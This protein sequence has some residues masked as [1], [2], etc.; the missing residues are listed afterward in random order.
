MLQISL[1]VKV[2]PMFTT[3]LYHC[4]SSRTTSRSLV[5][6]S[7]VALKTSKYV[8]LYE[9]NRKWRKLTSNFIVHILHIREIRIIRIQIYSYICNKY[10]ENVAELKYIEITVKVKTKL[11]L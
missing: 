8:L 4:V 11:S 10:F 5:S 1:M 3:N 7:A 2:V 9:L 6:G